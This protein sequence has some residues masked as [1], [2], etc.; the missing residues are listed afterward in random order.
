M[1]GFRKALV[2]YKNKKFNGKVE[3]GEDSTYAIKGVGSASFQLD[4]GTIIHIEEILYF[5]GLKKNLLSMAILQ[6][7]G[8]TVAFS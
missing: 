1:T 8:F 7:K 2:D 4:S 3:L 6:D 5:P